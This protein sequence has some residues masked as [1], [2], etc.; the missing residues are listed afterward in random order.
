VRLRAISRTGP[1]CHHSPGFTPDTYIHLLDD[2]VGGGLDLASELSQGESKVSPEASVE[3]GAGRELALAHWR[4]SAKTRIRPDWTG[5]LP[6]D[7]NPRVGSSSPFPGI[8][9]RLEIDSNTPSAGASKT[10]LPRWISLAKNLGTEPYRSKWRG[11]SGAYDARQ[12]GQAVGEVTQSGAGRYGKHAECGYGNACACIEAVQQ[13]HE[14]SDRYGW[15]R[16]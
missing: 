14:P 12:L 4:P 11:T 16:K 3:D 5:L 10:E 6:R 2:G 15:D 1:A 8:A 9:L 13:E 7:H